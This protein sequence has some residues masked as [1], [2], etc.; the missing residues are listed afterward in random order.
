[1]SC[2]KLVTE[3]VTESRPGRF[4]RNPSHAT[5]GVGKCRSHFTKKKKKRSGGRGGRTKRKKEEASR[6]P[7]YRYFPVAAQFLCFF[8]RHELG[9]APPET[10]CPWWGTGQPGLQ[11]CWAWAAG[12]VVAAAVAAAVEGM[13]HPRMGLPVL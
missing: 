9:K 8:T 1:M 10:A 2:Y 5:A 6:S 12:L 4:R 3:L 13:E 11:G 7:G